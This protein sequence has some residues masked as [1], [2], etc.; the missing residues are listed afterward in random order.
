MGPP[1]KPCLPHTSPPS[2]PELFEQA[3]VIARTPFTCGALQCF[4][5]SKPSPHSPSQM[6]LLQSLLR[7]SF[8]IPWNDMS[9]YPGISRKSWR[10]NLCVLPFLSF[11]SLAWY[12]DEWVSELNN[13]LTKEWTGIPPA[14][15]AVGTDNS[16][17]V[18]QPWAAGWQAMV[19]GFHIL[20][21][22]GKLFQ[23]RSI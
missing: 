22:T 23:D 18:A 11:R 15:G 2:D 17:S 21:S 9:C 1:A 3:C 19:R 5:L 12:P 13:E 8:P 14:R 20:G 7:L 10:S 4:S 16:D 6:P